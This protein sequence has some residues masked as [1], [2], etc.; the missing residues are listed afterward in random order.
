MLS[1]YAEALRYLYGFSDLERGTGMH[2][3]SPAPY[4][5]SRVRRLLDRL[6]DPIRDGCY[7]HVAGSKG[8]GSVCALVA[9]AAEAAGLR[10][11]FYT[12]PHLHTFRERIQVDGTSIGSA[13]FTALTEEVRPAVEATHAGAAQEGL[14]TTFE[15][16]TAMA[17][18]YF[19]RE[20][21]DLGVIEVGMGG[22][23]DAT[24][25]ISPRATA[26]TSLALEHTQIL[27][28]SIELIARE[29]AGIAKAG[30]PL[31][32]ARQDAAAMDPVA[33][34]A[35]RVGAPGTVAE[36]LTPHGATLWR[37]GRPRMLVHAPDT[38]DTLAL[39]LVGAHQ[40]LNAGVAYALCRALA[41]RD[42]PIGR[43]AIRAGFGA[44][45]WPARLE[46]VADSPVVVVDGAHTPES[47]ALAVEAMPAHFAAQRGPVI[48]GALRD[49]KVE[50]MAL[51]LQPFATRLI[52]FRPGHPRGWDAR[53]L[54]D[55]LRA[56]NVSVASDPTAALESARAACRPGEAVLALGSLAVAADIRAAAGVPC[57][58]DPSP[59]KVV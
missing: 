13:A 53:Q 6:G 8:K 22:G 39:G 17:L 4:R 40:R 27:G 12:Q 24:N 57:E 51:A 52:V 20:D 18:L 23:W 56:A 59:A 21:V 26:I 1:T 29:K 19:K 25:V 37:D 45:H 42:V 54:A 41:A 31:I 16:A 11:G 44:V 32:L 7:V 47:V 15:I 10:V 49:K 30:V 35:A 34:V 43:D 46:V 28:D 14:L 33:A 48:F 5:L 55:K 36:P 50:A 58:R 38:G 3:K 9:S 2:D